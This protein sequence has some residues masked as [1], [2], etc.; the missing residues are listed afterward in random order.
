[1]IRETFEYA[2]SVDGTKPLLADVAFPRDGK[3]KPLLVVMHGYNGSRTDVSDDMVVIAERGVF[4]VAPDMRGRGGSAGIWDSCG[5]D[6]HDILDATLEAVRRYPREI[7]PANLNIL[8]YSGGGANAAFCAVRFPDLF[9][10]AVA[11]FGVTD[12]AAWHRSKGRVDCN[13]VMETA[14]GGPPEAVPDAY[15]ARNANAL[16]HS[17]GTSAAGNAVGSRLHFFWDEEETQCPAFMTEEFLANYRAAGLSNVVVHASR[18][19]D[20]HR[21]LHGYP[22]DHPEHLGDAA[23]SLFLPDVLRPKTS[24]PRIRARGRF[25]VIGY[26]VTRRFQVWIEDGRRGQVTV[27]YDL[28]GKSPVIRVVENP[29]NFKVRIELSSPLA[30]LP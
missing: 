20:A 18:R 7:D 12:F 1:M 5:L 3:P 8:G 22:H 19:T 28:G 23:N 17:L 27:D 30:V 10:T 4:C 13:A 9:Q 25:V 26:L 6:V 2:S 29:G 24:S 15:A 11:F 14:L 21:W 16:S